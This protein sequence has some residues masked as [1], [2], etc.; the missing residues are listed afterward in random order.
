MEDII[1]ILENNNWNVRVSERALIIEQC[2]DLGEDLVEEIEY[3]TKKDFIENFE[4]I[5]KNFDVDEHVE[6]WVPMRG[7]NGVPDVSIREL[8]KDAE[9][10]ER[11]YKTTLKEIKNLELKK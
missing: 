4:R 7:K 3:T 6:L 8:Q 9:E 1:K 5:V 10:I 11:L 2:S